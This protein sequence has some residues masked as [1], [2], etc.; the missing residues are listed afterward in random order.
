MKYHKFIYSVAAACILV[1]SCQKD[2]LDRPPQTQYMD[3]N[4]WR[5]EEDVRLF[6][7]GFYTN[8]F[9]GFNSGFGVDYAPV[10]GYNF[11]DD[12]AGKNVQSNFE[13]SVPASRSST[14]ESAA[15]MSQYAGP[16]WNFAWV[17]KSNIFI[18][19][20]DNVAKAKIS[21][22]SYK[23]WMSVARFF[24]GF[25]YSRLVSV[26]GDVPYFDRVYDTN[27]PDDVKELYKDRDNR[28]VV[29]DKVYDDF[30]FALAN[31]R[32]ND[33]AQFLNRDIAAAFISRL[34]LFEGT[35]QHYHGL[36]PAR[37]KK[38]L[39]FAVEASEIVM[40]SGKYNFSRDYK[41]VFSSESLVG[42]PEVIMYRTYD[43]AL[44]VT[45]AI[46]SYSNGTETNGVDP[47]LNLIKS[48]V[49]NDGK[50]WQNSS[51]PN[52]GSFAIADLIKTR[53]PR[54]EASFV[55]KALTS[56]T[57]LLYGYKFASRDA[58][59]FIGKTYPAAWGSNTNTSD[60]PV[61]RLAEVVLNWIEAKAVLAENFGGQAVTQGDLDKSINA[62]RN[63][64]VEAA[65]AAKG[66]TKTAPL[67]LAALPVDPSKDADVS[68]LMWEIR[69]ERR[70]E[71]AF[72]HT[73]LNDI[74]RWKKLNYMN[75]GTNPDYLMGP[76][77]NVKAEAPSYL[78]ASFVNKVKVRKADGT[79][80]TYNGTNADALVGFWMVENASNRNAFTDRSYLAPIGLAQIN[81]YADKGF[82]LTQTVGW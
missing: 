5:N 2:V 26:F 69:R 39:E 44:G 28:G 33:G 61:I 17:R 45:H 63:R 15:W 74:R 73:R 48:F 36:D 31:I 72:E 60:A 4:Y 25:E 79:V 8:Y 56:S 62:I 1:T 47:N 76:W 53:D 23:H 54:F 37:A 34:M 11:S 38:Y 59:S 41:S 58:I 7:N 29:M 51:V 21:E 67:T 3:A 16:T 42:H 68:A 20:L 65:A 81:E 50:T 77:V 32:Q 78:A 80:V 66:V 75:F 46:G 35:W 57:T 71:F 13:G 14:L 10:R 19:R 49:A 52:A 43:A 24:R 9:P 40:N 22:E 55:D 27:N 64:P 70:M 82:K 30:K 18:D 6:A 12:L